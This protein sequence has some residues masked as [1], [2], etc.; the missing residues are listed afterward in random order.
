MEHHCFGK[1]SLRPTR[2]PRKRTPRGPPSSAFG[3]GR[4]I[5]KRLVQPGQ[6]PAHLVFWPDWGPV[7]A[8]CGAPTAC[9]A[10]CSSAAPSL[11]LPSAD[12][13]CWSPSTSGE[14]RPRQPGRQA[15]AAPSAA[16]TLRR[17]LN[18]QSGQLVLWRECTRRERPQSGSGGPRGNEQT[19]AQFVP[20]VVQEGGRDRIHTCVS[21]GC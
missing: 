8:H 12:C 9:D 13:R 11:R 4:A 15:L 16:Q 21:L 5:L 6:G 18:V 3:L 1:Y 14:P 7:G 17:P 10:V 20:S 2:R 19:R